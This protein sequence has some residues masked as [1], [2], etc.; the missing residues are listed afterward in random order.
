MIFSKPKKPL[1]LTQSASLKLARDR[2]LPVSCVIDVGVQRATGSL[3]EVFPDRPHLL[4][5]PVREFFPDIARNYARIEHELFDLALSDIDGEGF[6]QKS[7]HGGGGG[8]THAWVSG[9]GETIKLARLDTVIAKSNRK[10]PFL[11]KIDVDG[12]DAPAKIIEGAA[13]M[14]S[15]VSCVVSEMVADRFTDLA[16]R[17]ERSGFVLWDIVES[18]YYDEVFYQ[19]DAIFIR[20]DLITAHKELKPFSIQTFDPG[21][22]RAIIA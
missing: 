3:M 5:E 19:C 6:L 14:M 17:I 12:A 7:G 13:G 20:K 1:R 18:A 21:K 2:G 15:E 9:K 16:T 22:W 10:G 4:F 8:V 11:L